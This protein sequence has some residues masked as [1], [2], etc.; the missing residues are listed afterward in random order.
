MITVYDHLTHPVWASLYKQR[1]KSRN[2]TNGG[3]TYS[4]DITKY[5]LPIITDIINSKEKYKN[6]IIT[7]VGMLDRTIVPE[8]TDLIICYLH[9]FLDLELPRVFEIS[10]WYNKK[11]VYITSRLNIFQRLSYTGIS[12]ILLPMSIETSE[13]TKYAKSE[14]YADKR[15]IYFGNR[16]LGK[17]GTYNQIKESFVNKG[18]IFDE[19]SANMFNGKKSLNR[20]E[21]FDTIA[22]YKYGI[23]EGR[24]V[25]E[26]NALG[27][28]TLIC[29]SK[30]QGIFTNNSEFEIQKAN[31]F[32]DG[33]IWTFSPDIDTCIDNFDKA[34]I[35]TV[36]VS[37]V[38]GTLKINMERLL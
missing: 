18:W 26:M 12:T 28:K 22:K 15:V 36:D 20:D 34:I 23:G 14:K 7:T 5:H 16:Y 13:F 11:I 17:G 24:C 33:T 9:E 35:K 2:R 8:N 4:K 10:N 30:N 31:N 3:Y 37:E 1:H 21:I 38:M 6:V 29:A 25:L 19:I 32:S 27:V